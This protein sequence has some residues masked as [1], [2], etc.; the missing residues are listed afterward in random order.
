M[1]TIGI[2][3][4]GRA[5]TLHAEAVRATRSA[6]LA[7]VAARSTNSPK[8]A[9]L[10]KALDCRVMT[11][12][13][14]VKT[15]DAIVVAAPPLAHVEILH[16]MKKSASKTQSASTTLKAVLI[17]SPAATTLNAITEMSTTTAADH[18]VM[19]A[20]NLMH[21]AAVQRMLEVTAIM[22]P[23]HLHMRLSLP[24]PRRNIADSQAFGGG[25]LM[26]Q[27]PGLWPVL[28]TALASDAVS[29]SAP[30]STRDK[31]IDCAADVTIRA[32]NGRRASAVLR[33]GASV[34]EAS[35]EAA[36]SQQVARVDIWPTPAVEI[37]GVTEPLPDT[38]TR[39]SGP[40]TNPLGALGYV[41]QIEN[42]VEVCCGRSQL[43][44]DLGL[45]SKALAISA[46]AA[47]SIR[48]NGTEVNIS[49]TPAD[50]SPS[51][52]LQA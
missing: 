16:E 41:T 47:L 27:T 42:L 23:H 12:Q 32:A 7:G 9:A 13:Q 24:T 29:V 49:E 50:L 20:A 46:A 52:I 30:R 51:Q 17:E 18:Q 4:A 11:V 38:Q 35:F 33:W 43:W 8:A 28:L 19:V 48:R 22:D 15:C 2:I 21:A 36:D 40:S 39:R 44:P 25:V 10:A 45:A 34:A 26:D 1:T 3:G 37:N 5:A 14:L 31:G 6:Q